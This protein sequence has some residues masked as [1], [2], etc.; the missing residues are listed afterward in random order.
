MSKN[1][2]LMFAAIH[3]VVLA[4]TFSVSFS[5]QMARFDEGQPATS[6]DSFMGYTVHVL[7]T[8]MVW[9]WNSPLSGRMGAAM[10]WIVILFNSLLWG[11]AMESVYGG[12]RRFGRNGNS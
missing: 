5:R 7:A 3:F 2:I 4:I 8:P 10:E 9:F 12:R 6:V 11:L 1:R